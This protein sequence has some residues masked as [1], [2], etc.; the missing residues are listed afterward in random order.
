MGKVN[1]L[2]DEIAEARNEALLEEEEKK[3]I[4]TKSAKVTR[5]SEA[6]S[7]PQKDKS[8]ITDKIVSGKRRNWLMTQVPVALHDEITK[9]AKKRKM[10][11]KEFVY[12][13]L[14]KNG[15][16][17]IPKYEEIH[18]KNFKQMEKVK[19]G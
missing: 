13:S 3:R 2:E 18:G 7:K 15:M 12:D 5:N 16:S 9:E 6:S 19:K 14:R 17:Q 4:L 11:L 8:S 1:F 10:F